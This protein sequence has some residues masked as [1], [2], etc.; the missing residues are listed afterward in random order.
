MVEEGIS[1]FA[2]GYEPVAFTEEQ[3]DKVRE[4]LH[5]KPTYGHRAEKLGIVQIRFSDN[6]LSVGNL[7]WYAKEHDL[8]LDTIY[9]L[10]NDD[11]N[12]NIQV[13]FTIGYKPF[14]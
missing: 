3:L 14:E 6:F 7:L 4:W 12:D 11:T 8:T 5:A 1:V 10:N 2:Q 9:S 13:N